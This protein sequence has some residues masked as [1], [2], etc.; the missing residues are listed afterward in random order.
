MTKVELEAM[1]ASA[2]GGREAEMI[3]HKGVL[4][5]GASNDF[6]QA[7]RIAREMVMRYG[8]IEQLPQRTYGKKQQA[9]F[10]G[11]EQNEEQDYSEETAVKIDKE[12]SSLLEEGKNNA[13]KI[14]KKHKKQLELLADALLKYE[15]LDAE[16]FRTL[17]EGKTLNIKEVSKPEPQTKEK[18]ETT[19]Q[20]KGFP[21][22][23]SS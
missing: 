5:T 11:R 1:I 22:P 20:K 2:M 18:T 6:E 9:V 17:M 3:T 8:M 14:L 19:K 4:T 13:N 15:T 21:E 12:I 10:L 16:Q 23:Q 7:T